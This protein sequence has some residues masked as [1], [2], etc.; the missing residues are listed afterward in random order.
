MAPNKN[1]SKHQ[2]MKIS[3]PCRLSHSGFG[4]NMDG[5]QMHARTGYCKLRSTGQE[6]ASC[7]SADLPVGA[8]ATDQDCGIAVRYLGACQRSSGQA[9]R[10]PRRERC[11]LVLAGCSGGAWPGGRWAGRPAIAACPLS[12]A[13]RLLG[14]GHGMVLGFGLPA[15]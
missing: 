7:A 8:A 3:N 4:P 2:I 10:R 6:M 9:T 13:P 14:V 11:R 12:A 1:A 15:V 5:P